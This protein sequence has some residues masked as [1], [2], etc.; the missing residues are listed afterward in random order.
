MLPF[1]SVTRDET[2]TVVQGTPPAVLVSGLSAYVM[3]PR[4]KYRYSAFTV[5]FRES[6]HS[7]PPPIVQPA[8]VDET[9]PESGAITQ[10]PHVKASDIEVLDLR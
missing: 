5:Q 7:R 6:I 9:D 2:A 8:S 4:S 1:K 3:L 10:A